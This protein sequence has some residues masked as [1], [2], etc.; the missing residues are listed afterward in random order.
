MIA[1]ILWVFPSKTEDRV[2]GYEIGELMDWHERAVAR[3]Q[4]DWKAMQTAMLGAMTALR[5]R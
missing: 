1:D 3:K 5:R 4:A 2:E